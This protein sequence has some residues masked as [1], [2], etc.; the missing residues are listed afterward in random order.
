MP[1]YLQKKKS[2]DLETSKRKMTREK[3]NEPMPG[4]PSKMALNS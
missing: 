4:T 1:I 2:R 3:K